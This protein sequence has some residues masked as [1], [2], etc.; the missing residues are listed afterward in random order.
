[1][2]KAT[3]VR[4]ASW[5][6]LLTICIA[7]SAMKPA[8]AEERSFASL[9]ARAKSQ[10]A[11][12]HRWAPP[13]DNMGETIMSMMDLVSTATPSQLAELSALLESTKPAPPLPPNAGPQTND[14]IAATPPA[15]P[16]PSEEAPAADAPIPPPAGQAAAA[17]QRADQPAGSVASVAPASPSPAPQRPGPADSPTAVPSQAA[18]S[19]LTPNPAGPGTAARAAILFARGLEAERQGDISGARRFYFSAA[20]QGDGAAAHNLGRLYDPAYLRQTTMGGVEPDPAL[21]RRW[22]ETAIK[23][24]DAASI[25]LLQA[26]SQR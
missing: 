6:G 2:K 26:L 19:Q 4:C 12:G 16:E 24:G 9:L 15:P 22:Y 13:G 1:M 14:D 10:V 5:A 23:L 18:P 21:A 7:T 3:Q 20:Q 8:Q 17:P 25:P 11:A